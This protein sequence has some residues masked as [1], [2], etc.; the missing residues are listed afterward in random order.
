MSFKEIQ[1]EKTAQIE[2]I[3]KAY[4]PRVQASAPNADAGDISDVWRSGQGD[5]AVYGC[6]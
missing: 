2:Q 1:K 4:L 3:L 6:H 5:R